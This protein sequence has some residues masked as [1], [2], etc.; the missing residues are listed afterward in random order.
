MPPDTKETP[1]LFYWKEQWANGGLSGLMVFTK[2]QELKV[3]HQVVLTLGEPD[4]LYTC[5][6][7][8]KLERDDAIKALTAF[9]EVWAPTMKSSTLTTCQQGMA[10]LK[11]QSDVVVHL[12]KILHSRKKRTLAPSRTQPHLN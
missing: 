9:N 1:V 7:V 4:M 3:G 2:L 10:A 8:A 5:Q 12:L 6:V 11:G